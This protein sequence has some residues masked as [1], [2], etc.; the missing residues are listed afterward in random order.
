MKRFCI[1]WLILFVCIVPASYAEY[2]I[3]IAEA[4]LQFEPLIV[5]DFELLYENL[6]IE[7]RIDVIPGKRALILASSGQYDALDARFLD[8]DLL[9]DLIPINVPIYASSSTFAWSNNSE[10]KIE[11][12]DD[13][14]NYR[15]T[16]SA[17][18]AINME[19]NE[20]LD[21]QIII[22]EGDERTIMMVESGRADIALI[23]DFTVNMSKLNGLG[24]NLTPVSPVL[25]SQWVYHHVHP[26]HK[27][28]VPKIEAMIREMQ[29][30][31]Y[32][33]IRPKQ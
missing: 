14:K 26:R 18:S 11:E 5:S 7:T 21:N 22:V 10:I 32:F 19:F 30:E 9:K 31:G 29:E 25:H 23:S 1:S 4:Y 28:L 24:I 33:W 8:T 17:S 27:N 20:A 12:F 3:A 16:A 6:G 15:V 13:L 2:R